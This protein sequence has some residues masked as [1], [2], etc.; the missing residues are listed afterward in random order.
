VPEQDE[1]LD[2]NLNKLAQVAVRRRWW[3]IIPASVIALG[4]GL[5]SGL[6]P[7]HY[8]S[9]AT[10][11]VEHQQVPD[12]YVTPNTTTDVREALL[13]M[14]DAILSRT[15]LLQ[16][17]DE[18]GLYQKE[19]KRLSPEQLVDLMR[20][21]IKIE[22]VDRGNGTKDL[23]TFKISFISVDPHS[24]QDVT[25]TLSALFRAENLRSREE[26]ATGT[27][28]FLEDQ[29]QAAAVELRQQEGRVRDFKM[30]NLG[31]LPEQQQGNLAI[32]A[33]MHAQ[34]QNTNGTLARARE[35]Q[36]YLQSLLSQY[37]GMAAEGA[38][39][40]GAPASSTD[41]IKAEL[42]RLRK[43][44]A[45]LL[46]RYTAKYPDVVSIDQQIESTEALLAASTK[47]Q[48]A[49]KSGA[50]P[51]AK[52]APVTERDTGTAQLKSQLEANRLEIQNATEDARQIQTKIAEYQRRLNLTPVREQQLTD[53]LRGYNLAKQNYDDM[54]SKKTQS[55]L[56]T[57]LERRQQG[58]RFRVVDAPNLPTKPASPDHVKIALAGL[59]V[60]LAVGVA[61]AF[62]VESRDHS[63]REE[64]DLSRIFAFP[65][66]VGVPTLLTKTDEQKHSRLA[67]LEWVAGVTLC[68]L[69]C[70]TEFYVYRRG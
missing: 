23:D 9:E 22:P 49:A 52:P 16:I 8:V 3:V 28:A 47:A 43:E 26:Q 25:S 59:G 40:P 39:V 11:L 27:T 63:L 66:M 68:L 13:V 44:R 2:I 58:Q 6:V 54:L 32:L 21:N 60:G 38:A 12:R 64:K 29:L 48:E 10:I 33:G 20:K 65:L 4:V 62:W 51:G 42:A 35:Q 46:A 5:G 24:A 45:E 41:T 30:Q 17:I 31:E 50:S 56:A 37:E 36:A 57:S 70:A 15:Q 53:L 61:L 1:S 18:F 69:V 19:R 14:T 55:E 7:N 34:L 67:V